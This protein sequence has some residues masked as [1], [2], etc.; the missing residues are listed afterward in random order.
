MSILSALVGASLVALVVLLFVLARRHRRGIVAPEER[1]DRAALRMLRETS[2]MLDADAAE[3]REA[4]FYLYFK[5]RESAERA[6][7]EVATLSIETR[8]LHVSVEPAA[9]GTTWLCLVTVEIALS[10]RAIRRVC[11]A[12]RAVA[13]ANGGEFDGWEVALPW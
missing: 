2:S 10:D 12:L 7:A 6:S 13:T 4:S 5:S 3:P 8:R 1:A 9:R 11:A